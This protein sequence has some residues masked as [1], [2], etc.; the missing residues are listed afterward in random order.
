MNCNYFSALKYY[1]MQ[2]GSHGLVVMER[3][4]FSMGRVQI[5]PTDARRMIFVVKFILLKRPKNKRSWMAHFYN[6]I[7]MMQ[8]SFY[9]SQT[10]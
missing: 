2:G 8:S 1:V 5:L 4:P 7:P 6:I 3:G 10:K 9:P